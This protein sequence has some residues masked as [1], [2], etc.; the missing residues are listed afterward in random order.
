MIRPLDPARDLYAIGNSLVRLLDR[1]S[2][3]AFGWR[4]RPGAND[5]RPEPV[6]WR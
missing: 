6:E 4:V 3:P 5:N 1:H 2:R